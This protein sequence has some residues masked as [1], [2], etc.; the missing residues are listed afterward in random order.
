MDIST[1]DFDEWATLAKSAP[2]V[3]ELRR[4]ESIEHLIAECDNTPRLQF[5][6]DMERVRSHTAM[7]S[8]L[9]LS[10]LMWDSFL[11][12]RS[13]LNNL[14]YMKPALLPPRGSG[15]PISKRTRIRAPAAWRPAV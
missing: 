7:R 3:F 10:A 11:D 5:R 8:C 12:C 4:R 14:V 6:I 1:F 2:D 9:R 13:A 15:Y